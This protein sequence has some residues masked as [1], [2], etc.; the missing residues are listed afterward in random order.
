MDG[1]GGGGGGGGWEGRRE[2]GAWGVTGSPHF[3]SWHLIQFRYI[4]IFFVSIP[5][6]TR[7]YFYQLLHV[8]IAG[9]RRRTPKEDGK[10]LGVDW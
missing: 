10:R 5:S 2:G 6:K 8:L 4:F 9:S 3:F 7:L 1:G